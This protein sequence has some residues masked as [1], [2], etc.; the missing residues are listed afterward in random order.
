M[1]AADNTGSCPPAV[2]SLGDGT[3]WSRAFRARAASPGTAARAPRRRALGRRSR[4]G[5]AEALPRGWAP[6][7]AGRR[8]ADRGKICGRE[9]PVKLDDHL[10]VAARE[11][12]LG[13]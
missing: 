5:P 4:A 13:L 12:I 9:S 11:H 10:A 2:L 6:R 7:E 8:E 3:T 1:P